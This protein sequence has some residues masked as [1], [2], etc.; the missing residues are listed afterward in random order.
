MVRIGRKVFS[1]ERGPDYQC[2]GWEYQLQVLKN[3]ELLLIQP[4]G[5]TFKWASGSTQIRRAKKE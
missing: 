2:G 5:T 4:P 3:T 1:A